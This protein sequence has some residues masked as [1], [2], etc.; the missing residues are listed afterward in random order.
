MK[1]GQMLGQRRD[2]STD[3]GPTYIAVWENCTQ[4]S[5][6]TTEPQGCVQLGGVLLD[7]V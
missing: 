7:C 5:Q 4:P 2:D 3:V 6:H 1:V